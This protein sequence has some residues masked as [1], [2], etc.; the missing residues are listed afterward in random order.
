MEGDVVG[1][2]VAG[3]QEEVEVAEGGEEEEASR[4]CRPFV[5]LWIQHYPHCFRAGHY[6][7]ITS[8][9][10][11]FCRSRLKMESANGRAGQGLG[12]RRKQISVEQLRS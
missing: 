7:S 11:A 6:A 8:P 10:S 2:V 12:G 5:V 4:S 3:V 1:H 9:Q